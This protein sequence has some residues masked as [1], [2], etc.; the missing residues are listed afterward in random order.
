MKYLQI[1]LL[2]FIITTFAFCSK[3]DSGPDLG[4]A[5]T[6]LMVNA[7]V[8]T[9]NSGNVS[10]TAS[11]TNAISYDF[12]FGNGAFKTLP[13]GVVTY[14]YATSGTYTVNITA[15]SSTDLTLTK[16]IA[17]TVSVAV[18]LAWSEEFDSPG[19]PDPLKWSYDLGNNNGWGNSELEYYTNRLNNASVSNGTLK[20]TA[21]K[22]S[23][24]GYNYTS[25]RLVTNNKFSFKY[26]KIEVRAKLPSGLG[27]WPAIW[28][29]GSN[30]ATNPWPSCGEIDIMEQK[31]SAPDKIYSTLH[32]PN[33][34]G[35]NGN[36]SST[37]ITNATSEFHR[38]A[39]EWNASNIKFS[40]DDV[41]FYT[42][43]NNNT[44]PFNNNFFII[45][46]LA[47]GGNFTGNVD[48]NLNSAVFEVDYVRVY[49]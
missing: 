3:K 23:Y 8:S 22:E 21:V 27:V 24:Q 38:Y 7:V 29:L 47:M 48:P 11:A 2:F 49:Q 45:L 39:A 46:N 10:F 36:G 19:A 15:R 20:I 1:F 18:S 16:S 43:A 44:L 31:G 28:M 17:V 32:H 25:A 12:D 6:N 26:G 42:F 13:G 30:F 9:D 40:V 41:E 5:P 14:K 34:F 4:S 33:H 37:T 35:A